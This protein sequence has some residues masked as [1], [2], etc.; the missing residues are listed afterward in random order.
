MPSGT[1]MDTLSLIYARGMKKGQKAW[2]E[3]DVMERKLQ[4]KW[5]ELG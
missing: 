1:H 3:S 4:E 2:V 5:T